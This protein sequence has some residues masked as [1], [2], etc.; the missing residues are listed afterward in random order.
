MYIVVNRL[1]ITTLY[2]LTQ[3]YL[4][5]NYSLHFLCHFVPQFTVFKHDICQTVTLISPLRLYW[6]LSQYV[7]RLH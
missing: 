6:K 2:E 3:V 1:R 7:L 4:E 5:H